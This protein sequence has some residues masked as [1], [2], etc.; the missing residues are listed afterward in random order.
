MLRVV[1]DTNIVVASLSATSASHRLIEALLDQQ[2]VLIISSEILLE[3]EEVLT[4]KYSTLVAN[5]FLR[6]LEELPN[7]EKVEV[8]FNWNFITVD[9][10]DN[11]FVDTV[12]AAGQAILVTEDN[13]FNILHQIEFPKVILHN[14]KSFENTLFSV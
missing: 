2:Y 10:D 6:A 9:P 13:H 1:L 11:K 5:N 3:Y 7:V 12:I 8:F 14:L 4:R